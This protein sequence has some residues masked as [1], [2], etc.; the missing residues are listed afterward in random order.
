[1]AGQPKRRDD[2]ARLASDGQLAELI[3]AR[4]EEGVGY[5]RICLETHIGKAALLEW[6]D[7]E[8]NAER[9]SRARARAAAALADESVE[10]ADES[11]DPKLRVSTRQWVAERFDRVRFG[12]KIEHQVTGSVTHMHL[13][14]LRTRHKAQPALQAQASEVLDVEARE[15]TLEQQLAEL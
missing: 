4:L 2:L 9:A 10:I 12:Q 7:Q 14:A 6:L 13:A 1:M 8:E 5:T 11:R 3:W 15:L